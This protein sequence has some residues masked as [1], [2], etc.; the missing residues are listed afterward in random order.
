M[1]ADVLPVPVLAGDTPLMNASDEGHLEVVKML[2]ES[3]ADQA[4]LDL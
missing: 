2:L 3:R 4:T 1:V